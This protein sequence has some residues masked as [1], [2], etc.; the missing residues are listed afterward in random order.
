MGTCN[1]F[2]SYNFLLIKFEA[3]QSIKNCTGIVEN[4]INCKTIKRNN[5]TIKFF[6]SWSKAFCEAYICN[7]YFHFHS[8]FYMHKSLETVF[9]CLSQISSNWSTCLFQKLIVT[10]S[11]AQKI[12]FY[13]NMSYITIKICP[14]LWCSAQIA[15]D[16]VR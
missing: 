4:K 13:R 5:S 11:S 14:E 9:L 1:K 15:L 3:R 7:V 16:A 12:Y 2:N 10:F 8:Y 6:V